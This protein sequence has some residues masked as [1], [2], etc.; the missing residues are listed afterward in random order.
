MSRRIYMRP[1]LADVSKRLGKKS[2]SLG[3][4]AFVVPIDSLHL[5][6]VESMPVRNTGSKSVSQVDK[7]L[8]PENSLD[9]QKRRLSARQRGRQGTPSCEAHN[10][11]LCNPHASLLNDRSTRIQQV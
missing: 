6:I 10:C 4:A 7:F 9:F 8:L 2:I 11:D 1:P 3:S 5:F